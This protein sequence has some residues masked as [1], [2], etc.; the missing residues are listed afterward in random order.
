MKLSARN[1]LPG[2]AV[3]V[4]RGQTTA[5]VHVDIGGGTIVHTAIEAV[6]DLDL[7]PGNAVAA[8]VRL[9]D[10]LVGTQ[11]V[12]R[13]GTRSGG[14]AAAALLAALALTAPAAGQPALPGA[15]L[16]DA[17]P[18]VAIA[19]TGQIRTPRTL[20]LAALQAMPSVTVEVL[21]PASAGIRRIAMSGP[22]LWQLLQDA[23]PVDEPGRAT[24]YRHTVL[25]QGR[26][27]HSVAVAF[28]EMD[29][30]LGGKQV[31]IALA[32][33]GRPLAAPRLIVPGD[34]HADRAVRDLVMIEVR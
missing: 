6:D 34:A 4:A 22:A 30:Y 15:P 33:N 32:Q 11:I 24:Q 25:A 1:Q 21:D 20:T 9:P 2:E 3:S 14:R 13:P 18:A 10:V 17:T 16:A 26:N 31:L 29:P 19:L 23:G 28:G 12:G 7:Q 27:G 8:V 5:C